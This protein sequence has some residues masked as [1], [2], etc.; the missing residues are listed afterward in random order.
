[1]RQETWSELD[2]EIRTRAA[3]ALAGA[4]FAYQ[5]RELR[6]APPIDS[7]ASALAVCHLATKLGGEL[8][9]ETH[10]RPRTLLMAVALSAYAIYRGRHREAATY[11]ATIKTVARAMSRDSVTEVA[12]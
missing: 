4:G 1:M 10:A 8:R 12:S 6:A 7:E 3:D 5:A 2:R 11:M 9:G